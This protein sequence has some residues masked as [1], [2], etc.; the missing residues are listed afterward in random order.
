MSSGIEDI[1]MGHVPHFDDPASV[2]AGP[3]LSSD[4][5][6]SPI[7]ISSVLPNDNSSEDETE[8]YQ[9]REQLL[10]SNRQSSLCQ[11]DAEE[12]S[13]DLTYPDSDPVSS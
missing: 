5:D 10:V 3:D 1:Q 7:P 2:I 11:V 6:K 8:L 12:D 9:Y 13:F 4:E